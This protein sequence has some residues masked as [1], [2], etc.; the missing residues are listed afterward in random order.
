MQVRYIPAFIVLIAAAITSIINIVNNVNLLIGLK[1]LLIVII[2]FYIMGL[3]ARTVINKVIAPKPKKEET[4]EKQA[5]NTQ[6]EE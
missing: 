4:E 1:R 6:S 3:I 5:E 2:I